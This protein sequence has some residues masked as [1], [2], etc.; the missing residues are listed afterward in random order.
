MALSRVPT[1]L[2]AI[3]FMLLKLWNAKLVKKRKKQPEIDGIRQIRW[4]K[5]SVA[6]TCKTCGSSN[7]PVVTN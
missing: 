2:H 3:S 6:S 4:G 5:M 1:C 7:E